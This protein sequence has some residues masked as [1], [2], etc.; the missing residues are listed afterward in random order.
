[1]DCNYFLG[2]HEKNFKADISPR[3]IQSPIIER[4]RKSSVAP[5]EKGSKESWRARLN[6]LIGNTWAMVFNQFGALSIGMNTSDMKSNGSTVA[7]T[8]AGAASAL[9]IKEVTAMP[10]QLNVAVPTIKVIRKAGIA[11]IGSGTSN[12]NTPERTTTTTRKIEIN[13]LCMNLPNIKEAGGKGVP[14]SLFNILLSLAITRLIA[15]FVYEA[16]I[17][18]NAIIIGIYEVDK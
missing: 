14:L 9:G 16:F 5:F 18:E 6:G 3:N 15:I 17:T 11:L 4:F 2:C 7:F 12:M 8:M 10:K 1:M 13:A